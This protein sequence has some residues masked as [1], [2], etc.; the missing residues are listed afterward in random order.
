MNVKARAYSSLRRSRLQKNSNIRA[1]GLPVQGSSAIARL[2][3][4][5]VPHGRKPFVLPLAAKAATQTRKLVLFC[6]VP[7]SG[8][9]CAGL[10]TD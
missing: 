5:L 8:Q 6:A 10:Q 7:S 2:W 3:R 9:I 1:I 4:S